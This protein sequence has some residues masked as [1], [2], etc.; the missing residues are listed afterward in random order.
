MILAK[1][2][3]IFK[4]ASCVRTWAS[5]SAGFRRSAH[6]A[7]S[8]ASRSTG[9]KPIARAHSNSRSDHRS[10][11][12]EDEEEGETYDDENFEMF[13]QPGICGIALFESSGSGKPENRL[14]RHAEGDPGNDDWKERKEGSRKRIQRKED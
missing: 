8:G 9:A 11:D 10:N 1:L 6:C 4:A 13:G 12:F 7:L 5:V 14:C 3:T 2:R